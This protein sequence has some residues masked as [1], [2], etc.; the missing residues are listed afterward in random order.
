MKLRNFNLIVAL[1]AM[2]IIGCTDEETTS[3]TADCL[4]A[5]LQTGIIAF[6][7]FNNG[8][9][10]DESLQ[11]NDLINNTNATST[12]DRNGNPNCAY[13]FDNSQAI[14]EFLTTS[15]SAFLNNLTNFS[16]S[17]WYQPNDTSRDDGKYEILLSR[18]DASHCPDRRGEWS[19]GLYDCR[20]AVF[21][22]NN[23]V[24]ANRPLIDCDEELKQLTDEW[25]HVVAVKNNDEYKIYFNGILNES[26]TGNANCTNLHLA[27]DIGDLFLGKFYTGK[28]DDVIIYNR[29]VSDQEVTEL[30]QLETCC[31]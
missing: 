30:F 17:L 27:Q 19:V 31:D 5:N 26:A 11:G 4:S 8:S 20:R 16:V 12:S 10:I 6:Y 9:L 29:V 24:W 13:T 23:S 7:P 3:I 28:I 15:N 21:G 25:H 18:G 14:E 22:H 1:I 2:G